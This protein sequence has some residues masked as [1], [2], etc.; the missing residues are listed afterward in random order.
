M[1]KRIKSNIFLFA[2]P[3]IWG[4]AFVAQCMVDTETL[5][6]LTFNA[7]RYAIGAICLVPVIFLLENGTADAKATKKTVLFGAITGVILFVASELQM[8]GISINKSSGKSGFLTGLYMVIVPFLNFAVYRKRVLLKEWLA[9]LIATVGLFL[10][11]V[12]DGFD[13]INFGDVMVI[14]GTFFWA[15]H[16]LAIDKFSDKV[17][18]IKFS[19]VQFAV[20]SILSGIFAIFTE[21]FSMSG[22]YVNLLP[23]L[24]TGVFSTGIAYTFQVLGQRDANPNFASIV[25]ATEGVYAAIAGAILL[26]EKLTARGYAGCAL[27]FLGTILSQ[28]QIKGRIIGK[29]A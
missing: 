22:L 15:M 5:G 18:P 13:S 8:Y 11:S 12:T 14:A 16:I 26:G 1:N 3:M 17:T 25:L 9:A 27:M 23:V 7:I 29:K 28:L 24:Y 2:A 20:S 6:T 21:K 4:V 19:C 10:L